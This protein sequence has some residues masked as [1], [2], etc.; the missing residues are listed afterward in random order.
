M[1]CRNK[2][3]GAY[4]ATVTYTTVTKNELKKS[5]S[6]HRRP[7]FQLSPQGQDFPL[8]LLYRLNR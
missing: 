1:E 7:A 8:L 2:E 3:R 6:F 5:A 4:V